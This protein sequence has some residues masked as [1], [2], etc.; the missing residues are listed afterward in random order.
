MIRKSI[1]NKKIDEI[2]PYL[3]SDF[4]IKIKFNKF[5]KTIVSI[6]ELKQMYRKFAGLFGIKLASHYIFTTELGV[7]QNGKAKVIIG[8]EVSGKNYRIKCVCHF[9]FNDKNK[10]TSIIIE[11]CDDIYRVGKIL[12]DNS[13]KEIISGN[14][15][16]TVEK[17]Y[18]DIPETNENPNSIYMIQ[19]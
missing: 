16:D 14:Y 19:K 1:E 9:E 7:L 5:N 10:I 4:E 12:T 8:V 13:I 3:D 11:Q 2:I 6:N 17:E 18:D 15:N